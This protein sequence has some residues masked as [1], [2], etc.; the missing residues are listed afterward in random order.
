MCSEDPAIAVFGCAEGGEPLR[1]QKLELGAGEGGQLPWPRPAFGWSFLGRSN[2][3]SHPEA[4]QTL[5]SR[6]GGGGAVLLLVWPPAIRILG[7]NL[8]LLLIQ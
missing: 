2:E 1:L 4:L 8:L 6:G 3:S 7:K 5:T